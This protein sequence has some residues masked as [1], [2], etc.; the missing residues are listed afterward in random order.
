[1]SPWIRRSATAGS[2]LTRFRNERT[3]LI[4]GS[5]GPSTRAIVEAADMTRSKGPKRVGPYAVPKVD[6]LDGLG[7]AVDLVQDQGRQLFDLLGLRDLQSLHRRGLRAH[8]ARQAGRDVRRRLR[9]ARLDALRAVRRDGRDV[10]ALQRHAGAR[11]PRLRQEPRRLRHL[12]RRRRAGVGELRSRAKRAAR[13]SMARSSAMARP[14]T[15]STWWRL[16]ARARRAACGRRSP[17]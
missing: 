10:L 5:G 11:L 7:D 8:P 15:A 16:P 14:R 6:V 3:G 9:G 1:M 12:R 2:G 17:T 4:M 13:A